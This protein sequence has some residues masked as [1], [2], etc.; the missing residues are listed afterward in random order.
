MLGDFYMLVTLDSI[1]DKYYLELFQYSSFDIKNS[2]FNQVDKMELFQTKDNVTFSISEG[3]SRHLVSM[4]VEVS[5]T[6]L[7]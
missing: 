7:N 2:V 4:F 6:Y 1:D 5:Q 3:E